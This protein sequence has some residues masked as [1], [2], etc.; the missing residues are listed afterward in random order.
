MILFLLVLKSKCSSGYVKTV[1]STTMDIYSFVHCFPIL[2]YH[3]VYHIKFHIL[4]AAYHKNKI[5]YL[6][7]SL[8]LDE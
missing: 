6:L 4:D 8:A 1:D 7:V 2:D 3:N 5:W